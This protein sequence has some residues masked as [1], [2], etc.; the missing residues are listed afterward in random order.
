[1]TET[2]DSA[3]AEKLQSAPT[4]QLVK[5]YI[6]LRDSIAEK[7]REIKERHKKQEMIEEVLLARCN[8]AGGNISIPNLGRV[9]RK[10]SKRYWTTNWPA[11]Y[12]VI[13]EHDAFHL[14]HQRITT[15]AMEEF[16]ESHPDIMPEGLN[17]DSKHTVVV[18]RA[19]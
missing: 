3:I 18:T 1:M 2:N 9:A 17:L 8:D 14:L 15:T 19:S 4:E 16:L 12:Q 11:L 13:K 10:L 7:E 6:Q 5:L